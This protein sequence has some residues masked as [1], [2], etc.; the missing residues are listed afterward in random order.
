MEYDNFPN[1]TL[2]PG[3]TLPLMRRQRRF[4]TCNTGSGLDK[5][6]D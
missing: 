6:G 3:D 5:Q 2:D 4:S 1:A